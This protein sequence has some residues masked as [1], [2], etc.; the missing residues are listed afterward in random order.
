VASRSVNRVVA[1]VAALVASTACQPAPQPAGTVSGRRQ[2]PINPAD[3]KIWVELKV[4]VDD[5]GTRTYTYPGI[6]PNCV[7]KARW[8]LCLD[9][10]ERKIVT[11]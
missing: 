6:Q 1:L 4:D 7:V 3:G 11:G 2:L 5:R 8:P 10:P 9:L